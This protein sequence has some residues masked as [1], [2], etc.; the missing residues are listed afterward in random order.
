MGRISTALLMVAACLL[1]PLLENAKRAFDLM[2]QIGAGTGLLFILRWFW[3]R[4]NAFSEIAAMV[5]SFLVAFYFEF[6]HTHI[7]LT[8]VPG[9]LKLIIGVAITTAGWLIV[10]FLTKPTDQ[11]T[12]RSF[13]KVARPGGPG[14]KYVLLRARAEGDWAGEVNAKWDVPLGILCMLL[15]CVAVYSALF[16]TG[17]WLYANYTLAIIWTLLAIASSVLLFTVWRKLDIKK[18]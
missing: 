16:G 6:I 18:T 11:K 4:I 9:W 13:Y 8:P 14:W 2:L 7:G 17:Y 12:L 1:A 3:W 10:T 15:G 5:I